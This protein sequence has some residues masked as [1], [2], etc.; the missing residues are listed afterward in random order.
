MPV[1]KETLSNA[2]TMIDGIIREKCCGPIFVR[3]AWHDSGTFD[4]NVT[5]EWPAAGGAVGS[6]RFE[7]EIN[8]GAFLFIV[9]I[10]QFVCLCSKSC[11]Q[12]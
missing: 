4:K 8:H 11:V 3:L 7:P 9:Y 2:Q 10:W 12:R 6:I 1:T 5:G